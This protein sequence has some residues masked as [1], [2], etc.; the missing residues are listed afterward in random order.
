MAGVDVDAFEIDNIRRFGH[1]VSL[2]RQGF[3]L[4]ANPD[5]AQFNATSAALLETSKIHFH[6]IDTA[7]GKSHLRLDRHH[8]TEILNGGAAQGSDAFMHRDWPLL[9]E[10]QLATHTSGLFATLNV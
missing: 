8:T 10:Q 4:Y 5:S 6:W 1:D 3:L 9:L 7:F 2:K